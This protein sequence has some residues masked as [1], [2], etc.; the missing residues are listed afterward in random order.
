MRNQD[1]V[2]KI[3]YAN[4]TGTGDGPLGNGPRMDR[5]PSTAPIRTPWFSHQHDVEYELNGTTVL[6]IFDN[7][8]T[9]H[10]ENPGL[11]ENSRGMVLNVDEP[12]PYGHRDSLAGS[13][14]VFAG[15]G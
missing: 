7:G 9:R 8:N 4:G 12:T 11:S 1:W 15:G 14:C 5:S 13:R 6:S 2:I 10:V 3:D